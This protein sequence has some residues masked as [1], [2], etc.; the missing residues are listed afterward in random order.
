MIKTKEEFMDALPAHRLWVETQGE[1]GKRVVVQHSV[2]LSEANLSGAYLYGAYLSWANL[3]GA[4]LRGANLQG[5][6][7]HGAYLSGANLNGA[8][9]TETITA[10][11][12]AVAHHFAK[13]GGRDCFAVAAFD[14]EKPIIY[15]FCGC[16][17]GTIAAFEAACKAQYP[18]D[19]EEAYEAQ[20]EQLKIHFH[21]HLTN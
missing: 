19:P 12:S 13:E 4:N 16:F 6:T 20:I 2:N 9:L 1:Q 21:N 18:N 3:R 10:A 5:A 14:A 7:L 15:I 17:R 11:P 8:I